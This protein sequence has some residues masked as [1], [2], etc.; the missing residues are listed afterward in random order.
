MPSPLLLL[1]DFLLIA[2]GY[3]VCRYTALNR[4]IWDGAERLVYYLLFPVL[5]F[6]AIVKNPIQPQ[7][8]A[9]V[10]GTGI[11]VTLV[12]IALAL[13]L[14]RL[15]G[16]DARLHASGAQVAFRFNSY[17]A[18]ALAERLAGAQG[19]A[20]QALLTSLVVPLCNIA[21]VWP[22]ARQGGQG[23]LKELA[24]NPLIISTLAGLLANLAGL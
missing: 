20:W 11:A 1:P 23:Y 9:G 12:G 10:G 2:L 22:L 14:G 21:A 7:A 13:G 24:R 5:L 6:T 4:P 16:V 19:L 15:P 18:L 8:L 17:I 3:L